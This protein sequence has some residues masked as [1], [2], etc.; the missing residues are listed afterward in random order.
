MDIVELPN[1]TAVSTGSS[2]FKQ[3]NTKIQFIY[4]NKNPWS[5]CESNLPNLFERD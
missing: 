3:Q 1:A 5:N 4:I 2:L